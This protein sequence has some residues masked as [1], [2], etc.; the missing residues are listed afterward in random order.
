MDGLTDGSIS[1]NDLLRLAVLII[2][3][4]IAVAGLRFVWRYLIIGFSRLLEQTLRNRIFS[5][6]LR[7]DAPFFEKHTPG[8]L[9]AHSSNDLAAVQMACGMGMVA[10]AD[11]LV[12]SL[13]TIAFMLHIHVQLTLVA[14]LPMPFLAWFT[15]S[16]QWPPAPS[17][18]Y[19]AGTVFPPD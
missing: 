8:D 2:A 16:S 4:A 3:I 17:L 12:M 10:A 1:H 7:M 15:R 18:Q 11:A 19:R 13:A 9:M 6:L 14:L 5:H